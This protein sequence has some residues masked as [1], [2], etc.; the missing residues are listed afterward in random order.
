MASEAS[1]VEIFT[2]SD[3]DLDHGEEVLIKRLACNMCEN[4]LQVS[5]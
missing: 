5:S 3:I 4:S 2:T 1:F